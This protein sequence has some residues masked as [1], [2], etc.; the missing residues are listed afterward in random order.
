MRARISGCFVLFSLCLAVAA[1]AQQL[2]RP[3]HIVIVIE[4]NKAYTDV[5]GSSAAPY[6]NSLPARGALMTNYTGLHHPSQPNYLE[7]FSGN[8][9]GVCTDTCPTAASIKA[10]NLAA[11]LLAA[12]RT[13]VGFAENLPDPVTCGP[14]SQQY[15]RKHCPWLDF[16]GIPKSASQKF[17]AFPTT[18]AGFAKLPTVAIVIP[19]LFDD[20]HSAKTSGGNPVTKEVAQGDAWLKSH[21]DAY[22]TWAA[23]HNSLLIITWD[24]DSSNYPTPTSC[25]NGINTTPPA[26]RIPTIILGQHVVAGSTSAAAYSHYNLLRTIE[27][28]YGLTPIG[29]S[30]NVSSIAGIWN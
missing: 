9:Q 27:D 17:T 10:P 26:N 28:M 18:A 2:P 7:L 21:L 22:A 16:A 3:D 14:T 25:K 4:E 19:D 20:M 23:T 11:S 29:G 15:A 30:A 12:S 8:E 24:E 6:I 13:F 1:G 5:M